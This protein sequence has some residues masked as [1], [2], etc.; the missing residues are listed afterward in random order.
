MSKM[1]FKCL[2]SEVKN[3]EISEVSQTISASNNSCLLLE[4]TIGKCDTW[5]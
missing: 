1:H 3:R 5:S 4:L 2:A